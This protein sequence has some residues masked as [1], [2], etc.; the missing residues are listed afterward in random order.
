VRK[1]HPVDILV[2]GYSAAMAVVLLLMGRPPGEYVDE[3]LFYLGMVIVSMA[4]MGF[5]DP[6]RSR[7]HTLLRYGYPVLLFTFFYRMTGGY[8]FLIHDHWFDWQIAAFEKAILGFNPTLY[9]DQHALSVWFTELVMACYFSYYFMI[10][11]FTIYCFARGDYQVLKEGMTAICLTFFVSYPIFFLYPIEGPRYHF[12]GQYA[13]EVTGP[14]FREIVNVV[15]DRGA[16][17][18]GCMPSTHVAVSVVIL[19]YCLAHYR[20][21]G[22]ALLPINIGLAVGTVWGR[23]HYASDAVFGAA[24]ALI[25][26]FIVRRCYDRRCRM[27]REQDSTSMV[28]V[29][30]VA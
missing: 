7:W 26:T 10:P 18:G 1:R 12:A 19:L 16:V 9:I 25:C 15:I 11:G 22:W 24:I 8:L 6:A 28:R 14:F 4:V 2:I 13:N 17:H 27:K 21:L 5:V 30:H 23:F 20:K 29:S 3:I